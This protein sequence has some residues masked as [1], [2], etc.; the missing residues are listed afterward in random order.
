MRQTRTFLLWA[1]LIFAAAVGQTLVAPAIAA[2]RVPGT[3]FR[4]CS[5]CPEMV[6]IPAGNFIMG[7]SAAEKS[8]AASHGGNLASVADEAPQH[9]VDLRSFALGKYDVTR[10]EYAAFVRQTGHAAG[11]GCGPD[12]FKWK[13]QADVTWENPGFH[14]TERDPVVCVS[15]QD[16]RDYVT[17]LN[18]KVR[19]RCV[20]HR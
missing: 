13:K 16:A 19:P 8:W 5:N 7:S 15:W 6:V 17:W 18:G 14:Q 9:R 2:P 12:S 20:D 1:M 10:S 4:D 3:V 11:D